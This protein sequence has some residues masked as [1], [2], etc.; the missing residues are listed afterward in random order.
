L[1]AQAK[2]PNAV[3]PDIYIV[4]EGLGS[5]SLAFKLAQQL[6]GAG[7]KVIQHLGG[8]SFKTQF[9]KADYVTLTVSLIGL[10]LF[11]FLFLSDNA[12]DF[13]LG[14][15]ETHQSGPPIGLVTLNENDVR[16]KASNSFVWQEISN[17]K[18]IHLG[19]GL[20]TGDKSRS[21]VKLNSGSQLDLSSNSLVIFSKI[22]G[23]EVPELD[24]GNIKVSVNG[25]MKVAINGKL[26]E[27]KGEN[28]EIEVSLD[29]ENKPQIKLLRGNAEIKPTKTKKFLKLGTN[30]PLFLENH[31]SNTKSILAQI[32][33]IA[34]LPP[35][36]KPIEPIEPKI[37][38]NN[39][40]QKTLIYINQLYDY[41]EM[42]NNSLS[43]RE[44]RPDLLKLTHSINWITEGTPENIFIQHSNNAEFKGTP[45]T[46]QTKENTYEIKKIYI[47]DNFWRLSTDGQKWTEPNKFHVAT[48]LLATPPPELIA[49]NQDLELTNENAVLKLDFQS[50]STLQEYVLEMSRDPLFTP[51]SVRTIWLKQ[52]QLIY[53]FISPG[54]YY[55]R[56]RGIN[57]ATEVTGYS[58]ILEIHV[59]KIPYTAKPQL[60]MDKNKI[61]LGDKVNFLWNVTEK[62]K[63]Y[64]I[65]IE[66][67]LGRSLQ[68]EQTSLS[69]WTWTPSQI[70]SY[71]ARLQAISYDNRPSTESSFGFFM[72]LEKPAP[73][74]PPAPLAEK[75]PNP[76]RKPASH[77]PAEGTSTVKVPS[78]PEMPLDYMN[79]RYSK[80][81]VNLEGAL[82]TMY[83]NEQQS[84]GAGL[85][86]AAMGGLR[87]L[88]WIDPGSSGFEGIF[89][90]KVFG[91]S[92]ESGGVSP[93][94]FEA[95]YHYRWHLPWNLL[96]NAGGAKMSLLLGYE[97]YRNSIAGMFVN[98]YQLLKTGFTLALPLQKY[99][100]TG[101]EILY[102]KGFDNSN[103]Y[104]LSGHLDYFMRQDFSLGFGYRVHLFEGKSSGTFPS[105]IGDYYDGFREAYSEGYSVMRWHLK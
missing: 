35:E 22:D 10:A 62:T 20:F 8:G 39:S 45:T 55:L 3:N 48:E 101:G 31:V 37:L 43:L 98:Q 72:V 15:K 92:P 73:P 85:P 32:P 21:Q 65:T 27:F 14:N 80:S 40:E 50:D 47:G 63:N 26:T 103:K 105:G 99:W 89:R 76:P 2:L 66:D 19:D 77:P 1:E 75:I 88:K 52:K 71:V 78:I 36:T 23:I 69:N 74:P 7:F 53:S 13:L 60:A 44:N 94:D 41:Y 16:K 12:F 68:Q 87:Y 83:S 42:K 82:F 58:K 54:N 79:R 38:A 97:Y 102:G 33:K 90:T 4:N 25:S 30:A 6:R 70:G 17:Q 5:S 34:T 95:R 61:Y 51:P 104:E 96:S 86:I 18:E 56:A 59:R 28:A 11:L 100:E 84:E 93:M 9:K 67:S 49:K 24:A 57:V 46:F 64:I 29:K 91:L 81:R